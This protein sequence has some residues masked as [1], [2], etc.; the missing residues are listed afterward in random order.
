MYGTIMIH[1]CIELV[2]S[3]MNKVSLH[4]YNHEKLLVN[5]IV[6]CL[7]T[8]QKRLF[9]YLVA[10][11]ENNRFITSCSQL[12]K[13]I[14]FIKLLLR[15]C[16]KRKIM[17]NINEHTLVEFEEIP[18][19]K[20]T[21][22]SAI[23]PL[24]D[25]Y[26][27]LEDTNHAISLFN[28]YEL[29]KIIVES[30]AQ[31][32]FGMVNPKIPTNPY[33]KIP[34]STKNF[35]EL[36]SRIHPLLINPIMKQY[37]STGF[38]ITCLLR[39]HLCCMAIKKHAENHE[40]SMLFEYVR[41]AFIFIF[42]KRVCIRCLRKK[43]GRVDL[44]KMFIIIFQYANFKNVTLKHI[45]NELTYLLSKCNIFLKSNCE[46]SCKKKFGYQKKELINQISTEGSVFIFGKYSDNEFPIKKCVGLSSRKR[47]YQKNHKEKKRDC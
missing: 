15:V 32:S 12:Y 36:Y 14:W 21:A 1:P 39:R 38:C 6:S 19:K 31:Q 13:T 5:A 47:K 11:F 9:F 23:Y 2:Y 26:I 30:L 18:K 44:L 22:S 10:S 24:R 40:T 42:A 28:V 43:V 46:H 27:Q 35:H 37:E 34:F 25:C 3:S 45:Q 17:K 29:Q 7:I 20:I 41:H 8:N 16:R 33:T 4:L